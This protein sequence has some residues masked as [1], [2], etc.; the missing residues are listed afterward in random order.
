[1]WIF[2]TYGFFSV[3]RSLQ[4]PDKIQIRARVKKDLENLKKRHFLKGRII[5]TRAADYRWRVICTPKQ[6][7]AV[8]LRMAKEITYPNFKAACEPDQKKKPLMAIWS[9][10]H[11]YQVE[12]HLAVDDQTDDAP[13]F[14][15]A[16][17]V[18]DEP[19]SDD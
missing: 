14:H 17:N 2:K 8:A 11:R 1:M 9:L 19:F 5:E 4:E 12:E 16:F 3:T 18:E 6:W 13:L 10:L 15:E 7:E